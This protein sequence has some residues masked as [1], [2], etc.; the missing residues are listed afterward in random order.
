MKLSSIIP[1]LA[2]VAALPITGCPRPENNPPQVGWQEAGGDT[3]FNTVQIGDP[4]IA[5]FALL[6]LG[7]T[8]LVIGGYL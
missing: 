1:A 6:W 3:P 2:A 5:I 4:W 7:V 8:M